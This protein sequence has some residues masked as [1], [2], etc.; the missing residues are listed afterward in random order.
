MSNELIQ[1]AEVQRD[2]DGHWWHPGLPDFDEG[3][4]AEW[5]A[6]LQSQGLELSQDYLEWE[7]ISNPAYIAY[8]VEESCSC[9]LWSPAP[10]KGD[11]WFTLLITDTE[12]G[13]CWV[14]ARRT[15]TAVAGDATWAG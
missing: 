10:P 8:F 11:G 5:K 7:D 6:W 9:A 1:P 3:Q 14:W 2:E 12:D 15:E 4:D 13:P